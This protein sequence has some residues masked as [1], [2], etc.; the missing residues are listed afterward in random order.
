MRAVPMLVAPGPLF[1]RSVLGA[2]SVWVGVAS[3]LVGPWPLLEGSILGAASVWMGVAST[4]VVVL[5]QERNGPD[6]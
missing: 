1:G 3:T 4:V 5:V 2:A 6:H